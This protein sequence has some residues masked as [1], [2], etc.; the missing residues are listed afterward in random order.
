MQTTII[1]Y[2]HHSKATRGLEHISYRGVLLS[3]STCHCKRFLHNLLN[4]LVQ[5]AN[6]MGLQK[7]IIIKMEGGK[8][9]VRIQLLVRCSHVGTEKNDEQIQ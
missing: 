9:W 3:T 8:K 6:K 5:T 1:Y 7:N 4:V 2:Y